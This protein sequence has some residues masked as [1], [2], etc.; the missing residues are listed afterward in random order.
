MAVPV[1]EFDEVRRNLNIQT[2]KN[3]TL[4]EKHIKLNAQILLLQKAANKNKESEMNA[5]INLDMKR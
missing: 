4:Q 1:C 3:N 2:L 5:Q